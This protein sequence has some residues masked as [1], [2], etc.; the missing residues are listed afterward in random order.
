MTL[1]GYAG[2][3]KRPNGSPDPSIMKSEA[4]Q[5]W[6]GV[7]ES[8][9]GCADYVDWLTSEGIVTV[10]VIDKDSIA[11]RPWAEAIRSV[12]AMVECDY[13]V[14][15]NEADAGALGVPSP[16]SWDMLPAAYAELYVTGW[17]EISRLRPRAK[18]V[19]T[20]LVSGQ[21]WL[22]SVYVRECLRHSVPVGY[23]DIHPWSKN[24]EVAERLLY[25]YMEA[26]PVGTRLCVLEWNRPAVQ[27]PGYVRMLDRIDVEVATYFARQPT[28]VNGLTL[29]DGSYTPEYHALI[30]AYLARTV[31]EPPKEEVKVASPTDNVGDG[32]LAAMAAVGDHPLTDE[33]YQLTEEERKAKGY[34]WSLTY[35][36]QGRYISSNKSGGWE[37]FGPLA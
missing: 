35:G 18:I 17:N 36:S 19:M 25:D 28:D 27:I 26:L 15:G 16:Y 34:Q 4:A 13:Y 37:T 20:G 9:E 31:P 6:R 11:G 8:T 21:S 23:V 2:D 10:G 3:Y 1:Q 5:V 24:E 12:V 22:G 33:V 7:I 14:I 30:D 32:V 29:D